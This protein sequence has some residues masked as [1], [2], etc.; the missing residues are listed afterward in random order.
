MEKK[1]TKFYK[2]KWFMWVCLILLPPIG[3][4]LLWVFQKNMKKITRIILTIVFVFWFL[5]LIACAG[6]DTSDTPT[7]NVTTTQQITQAETTEVTTK[8]TTTTT[9]EKP[10]KA[11]TQATTKSKLETDGISFHISNVRNDVTGNWRIALISENIQ[12]QDYAVD[13]YKEYFKDD[14]EIHAIVNFNYNT[15]TKLSVV[16]DSIDV[17][18]YEYVDKEEHDAQKLLVESY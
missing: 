18:V 7:T 10:T 15:T 1:K 3:I 5:V 11:T 12:M 4:V 6:G 17:T 2:S 8:S 9:T 16:G 14:K 13:Y